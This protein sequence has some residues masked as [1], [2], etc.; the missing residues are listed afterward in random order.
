M[1][2][3]ELLSSFARWAACDICLL[4]DFFRNDA[5]KAMGL[6]AMRQLVEGAADCPAA[7]SGRRRHALR[8][9][10]RVAEAR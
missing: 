2:L 9:F 5:L 4:W 3:P 10:R 7:I 6:P 8:M 1:D